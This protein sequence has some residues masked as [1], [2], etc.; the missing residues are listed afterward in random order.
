MCRNDS[1]SKLKYCVP[2]PLIKKTH[3]IAF[4]SSYYN[5]VFSVENEI[6]ALM[7][8]LYDAENHSQDDDSQEAPMTFNKPAP[9]RYML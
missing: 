4:D 1:G 9:I 6:N 2:S 5:T 8:E 3:P 7:E